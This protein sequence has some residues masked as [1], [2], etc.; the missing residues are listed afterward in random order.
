MVDGIL[1]AATVVACLLGL[2]PFGPYQ[3]SL[4]VAR[5]LHRFPPTPDHNRPGSSRRDVRHMFMRL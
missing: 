4:I 5:R 2:W 1:L 3:L